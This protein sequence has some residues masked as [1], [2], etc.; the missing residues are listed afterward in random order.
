MSITW[1]IV[2]SIHIQ[3]ALFTAGDQLLSKL[4]N[5]K[6]LQICSDKELTLSKFSANV[7]FG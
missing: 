4:C 2:I 1:I 3:T 5:A 7:Y 6:F